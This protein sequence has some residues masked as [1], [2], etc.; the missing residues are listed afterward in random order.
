MRDAHRGYDAAIGN[1]RAFV[2]AKF[3]L[4]G[5]TLQDL[6]TAPFGITQADQMYRVLQEMAHKDANQGMA[7]QAGCIHKAL[8]DIKQRTGKLMGELIERHGTPRYPAYGQ[9]THERDGRTIADRCNRIG[10]G[11]HFGFV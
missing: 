9:D 11:P 2:A 7:E 1:V 5:A 10:A 4:F 3:T 6:P 8:D